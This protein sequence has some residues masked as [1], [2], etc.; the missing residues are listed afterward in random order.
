M[1]MTKEDLLFHYHSAKERSF[2]DSLDEFIEELIEDENFADVTD[3][4]ADYLIQL[5][6]QDF[7]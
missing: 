5:A 3:H 1:G 4:E 7:Q 6:S 2:A